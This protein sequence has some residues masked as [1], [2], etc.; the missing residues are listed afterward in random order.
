MFISPVVWPAPISLK[1]AIQTENLRQN[2]WNIIALRSLNPWF[3]RPWRLTAVGLRAV[4]VGR[5]RVSHMDSIR[6]PQYLNKPQSTDILTAPWTRRWLFTAP[7]QECPTLTPAIPINVNRLI[8]NHFLLTLRK[9]N[10]AVLLMILLVNMCCECRPMDWF[11]HICHF[12]D[13]VNNTVTRMW[14]CDWTGYDSCSRLPGV[15]WH[16][17]LHFTVHII[18]IEAVLA[19]HA[20]NAVCRITER[21][22]AQAYADGCVSYLM[23]FDLLT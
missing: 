13:P 17:S 20:A 18:R 11:F 19:G 3:I 16:K 9:V 23:P 7:P 14:K 15:R 5:L 4:L 2:P 22:I 6:F 8:L 12:K 21:V 10:L 1:R